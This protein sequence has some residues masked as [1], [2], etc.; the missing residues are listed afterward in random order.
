MTTVTDWDGEL[1]VS[2]RGP[3]RPTRLVSV[4]ANQSKRLSSHVFR[5]VDLIALAV[6]TVVMG[7]YESPRPLLS[8]PVRE[9]LP[10]VV[11]ALVL[12]RSLRSLHLYRFVR[13][14]SLLEHLGQMIEAAGTT[15]IAVFLTGFLING[16]SSDTCWEWIGLACA[17]LV[18]LHIGWWL[19]VR[20]WR[21]AGWLTPNLVVVGANEYAERMIIDALARRH[22]NVVGV[23]DDRLDRSPTDVLGVPVL[24]DIDALLGHK[25]TPYVDRIVDRR[26]AGRGQAGARDRG[27]AGDPAERGHPVP[28]PRR[29]QWTGGRPGAPRGLTAG[30]SQRRR[31]RRP[32]GVR[33][34]GAGPADRGPDPAAR[35]SRSSP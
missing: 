10:L 17:V 26:R 12:G 21:A 13:S 25:I 5:T 18:V 22:V 9:L 32:Q 29:P 7:E 27:S 28:R 24:G 11:G 8:T 1:S 31:R 3:M 16:P 6:V 35:E 20:A 14:E 2:R 19:T 23:F 15:I 34:A 30:R 4:R 33:Q